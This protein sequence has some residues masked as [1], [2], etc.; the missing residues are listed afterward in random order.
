MLTLRSID[1]EAL[2]DDNNHIFGIGNTRKMFPLYYNFTASF[3]QTFVETNLESYRV[4]FD[5][6]LVWI[7]NILPEHKVTEP[8][9]ILLVV[10]EML[11]LCGV[12]IMFRVSR[13]DRNSIIVLVS[14]HAYQA[15]VSCFFTCTLLIMNALIA[16][17]ERSN[18]DVSILLNIFPYVLMR[19]KTSKEGRYL[20]GW[21][22]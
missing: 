11:N 18:V 4:V 17:H 22:A 14:M 1:L 6:T 16:L 2:A 10:K 9:V 19:S 13:L 8:P 3:A 21:L 15:R 7:Q 20:A 5:V 12:A